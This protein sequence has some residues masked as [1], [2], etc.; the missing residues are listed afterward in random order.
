[1]KRGMTDFEIIPRHAPE[2]IEA[3]ARKHHCGDDEKVPT[4]TIRELMVAGVTITSRYQKAH[5]MELMRAL[6]LGLPPRLAEAVKSIWCDSKAGCC[7]S[8][9]LRER[10]SS[11]AVFSSAAEIIGACLETTLKS[12]RP[13]GHNGI[14]ISDAKHFD[15]SIYLNPN[16]GDDALLW[17]PDFP[18]SEGQP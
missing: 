16:W 11:P 2:V 14:D 12:M 1:M 10:F 6:I 9:V 13:F 7:Y 15:R 4:T 5:E 17:L 8:V 3:L 18:N